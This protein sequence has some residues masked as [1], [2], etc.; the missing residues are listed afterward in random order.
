MFPSTFHWKTFVR[1]PRYAGL[2]VV[3][4]AAAAAPP[5]VL[6]VL[7]TVQGLVTK[8]TRIDLKGPA[9]VIRQDAHFHVR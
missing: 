1:G 5:L 2:V 4:A 7:R 6:G 3:V 9:V 8:L